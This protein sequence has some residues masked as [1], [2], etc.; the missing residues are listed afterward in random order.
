MCFGVRMI[1]IVVASNKRVHVKQINALKVIKR[2]ATAVLSWA[3][4]GGEL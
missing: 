3:S 4:I 1:T 2:T